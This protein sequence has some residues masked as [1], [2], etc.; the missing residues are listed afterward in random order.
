[1]RGSVSEIEGTET[2]GA[3]IQRSESVGVIGLGV[4]GGGIARALV[5]AGMDVTVCDVRTEALEPFRTGARVA[6]SPADLAG[7]ADTVVVAVFDDEQVRQVLTGAQGFLSAARP[8]AAIV[9]VS[10]VSLSTIREMA[11]AAGE[12][13]AVLVDCGV[14]GGPAAAAGGELVALIGGSDIDVERVRPIVAAFSS[15]VISMGPLGT[16]IQAKLARNLIQ[17][18]SWLAAYEGQAIAEAA[19]IDLRKLAKAVRESDKKI[20]GV[21]ALMF[22]ETVAPF[23]DSDDAGI[24]AMMRSGAALAAKDLGAACQLAEELGVES[25]LAFLAL[26]RCRRVFG[27]E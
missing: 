16:G 1:M 8:S 14:T 3:G 15:H 23:G 11:A 12:R 18:G 10:T 17:Y 25:P 20:G 6:S 7:Y 5:T 21:S 27:I 22:R 4:I 2:T 19:G 9:V 24:V 13:D 26:E